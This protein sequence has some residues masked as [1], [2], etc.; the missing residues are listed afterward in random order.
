MTD[1]HVRPVSGRR[2][3]LA[4]FASAVVLFGIILLGYQAHDSNNE[5]WEVLGVIGTL[6]TAGSLGWATRKAIRGDHS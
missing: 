5:L 1:T 2:E 6:A 3:A 4:G